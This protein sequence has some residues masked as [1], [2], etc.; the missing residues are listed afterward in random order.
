MR[1]VAV[2][3]PGRGSYT[4]DLL[5]SLRSVRSPALAAAD[6]FRA[7][8]GRPT[9][10]EMDAAESYSSRL[11]VA[12]ENASILT[13]AATLADADALTDVS[14]ACVLGNSMGWYTA[15]AVAGA[16][17]QGDAFTLVETMAQYQV[18]NVIGGQ[19]LY[20]LVDDAWRALPSP[21]L[22][23]ALAEIP[24]LHWSIRLG[25]QA[26][27]GGTQAALDALMKRLPPRKIGDRDAPFQLPLH[28][29]F[30]TPL[31]AGT[32]A[33][34]AADL[35]GLGWRAPTV[36]LIDGRGVVFRPHHADPAAL[37]DYTLGAQVT[38]PY[39][40]GASVRVALRE[41]APDAVVLLGPGGNLGGAV[42]QVLIEEG[43][44]RLDSRAAFTRAQAEAPLV[45]S[46]ARPEQRALVT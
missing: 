4:R 38:E 17:P 14:V 44:R 12:G 3:C 32:S 29:A 39:D 45:I 35:A 10:S 20:P 15:L 41:Y 36:P 28:S 31:M 6:A 8:L 42:A 11:H 21:E 2:V 23:A 7:A 27:L 22:A 30:H 37:R 9:P 19:V 1:R 25:G 16:L 5:G 18:A 26:V 13:M 24:D 34:A 40:F 33:R 43:W 46:L